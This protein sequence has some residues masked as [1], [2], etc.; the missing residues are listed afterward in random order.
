LVAGNQSLSITE[1]VNQ[2]TPIKSRFCYPQSSKLTLFGESYK[3]HPR[4][5]S[6]IFYWRLCS[7][8]LL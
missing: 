4:A 3:S 2:G 1:W 5:L 7:G 8:N 6:S